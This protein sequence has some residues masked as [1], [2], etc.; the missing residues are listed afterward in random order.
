MSAQAEHRLA[1]ETRAAQVL[2]A[3]LLEVTDDPDT[4]ADTIEGETNLH[5]AIAKVMAGIGEDEILCAGIKIA[6]EALATRKARI[7]ARIDRR[8]SA[9]ERGMGAGELSKLE[10][11]EATISV[12]R[13][14]PA[15]QVLSEALIPPEYFDPQPPRLNR[16][17]LKEAL[18]AG[19]VPGA[20][21]DNG[22][23][24]LSIRRA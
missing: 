17:K 20:A 12:R 7:E 14:P 21:F 10:L 18:R 15:L 24:T 22:S 9:I 8:R 2:K 4:L 5:E 11:P 23:Q 19:D 13:V 3:A 16:A 6:A 1:V